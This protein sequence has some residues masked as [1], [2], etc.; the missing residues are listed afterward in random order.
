MFG[1]IANWAKKTIFGFKTVTSIRSMFGGLEFSQFSNYEDY[2]AA[3]TKK[4]AAVWKA[5]DLIANVVTNTP[6]AVYRGTGTKP[7]EIPE[8]KRLFTYPNE[9]ETFAELLYKSCFHIDLTGSAFWYKSQSI[10]GARPK[11]LFALNPSRIKFSLSSD[12]DVVG[13]L[14]W[15]AG[16]WIPFEV[17]EVM[18]FR[19]P[20]A[21]ND[22]LGLGKI[23]G[24]QD[25]VQEVINRQNWQKAFF[26]N[27]ASVSGVMINEDTIT[28]I[29]A[30]KKAQR[31]W[32][33]DHGGQ[34]NSGKLA[35]LAGKWKYERLGLTA[36]EMQDIERLQYNVEQIYQLMGVPL[37]VAGV[38]EAANLATAEMDDQ[39]FREM[40]V[41]PM[42]R[43]FQDTI[44]TD[45]VKD[46]GANLELRFNVTGLI[47]ISK[48]SR[49]L[50]P[51][52][53]RGIISPN[54]W[55]EKAGFQRIERPEMNQ[56]YITAAYVP[57]EF[58]GIV[59]QGKTDEQAKRLVAN[60]T[61]KLLNSENPQ[62]PV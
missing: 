39:R 28:D 59:D 50:A 38:K 2:L 32:Q 12:G 6:H 5:C 23:E 26:K 8:L 1:G 7:V 15:S 43:I 40:T 29:D 24:G 13:Y 46:Y 20:H 36:Q 25:L 30:F 42:V 10:G 17:D 52:F 41:A 54:E 55:R 9:R 16:R 57:L 49:D 56:H 18:H 45:L 4:V 44:N 35:W 11:E 53:D 47:N 33:A 37:S 21:N 14:Y 58:A 31:E 60:F 19:R 62:S 51:M 34:N 27:G 61:A 3:G 22:Y 48:I